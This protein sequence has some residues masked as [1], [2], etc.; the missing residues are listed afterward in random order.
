VKILV[1]AD[2]YKSDTSDVKARMQ[3]SMD[4]M[5]ANSWDQDGRQRLG[6]YVRGEGAFW[7]ELMTG[8]Q[9]RLVTAAAL[10]VFGVILFWVFH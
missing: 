2:P 3:R 6:S 5:D 7:A 10:A 9:G 8:W 1:H 4:A